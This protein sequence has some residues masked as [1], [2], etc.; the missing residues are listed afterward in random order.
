MYVSVCMYLYVWM[1][2]SE[3][4]YVDLWGPINGASLYDNEIY[5][6][7][8]PSILSSRSATACQCH[9]VINFLQITFYSFQ[10]IN[11]A[12]VAIYSPQR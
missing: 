8:V 6:F 9:D 2:V 5:C 10:L 7:P 4:R 11:N 12:T 3:R 1:F